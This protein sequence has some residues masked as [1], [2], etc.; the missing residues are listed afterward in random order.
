MTKI[1]SILLTSIITLSSLNV[2]AKNSHSLNLI[3]RQYDIQDIEYSQRKQALTTLNS[4][5]RQGKSTGEKSRESD[6]IMLDS[7]KIQLNLENG[8][9]D[10]W[11]CQYRLNSQH[12]YG[13]ADWIKLRGKN[14]YLIMEEG[15]FSFCS[16]RE[17]SWSIQGSK[18]L[19]DRDKSRIRV[20]DAKLRIGKI[21]VLYIPYLSIPF[22]TKQN[23]RSTFPTY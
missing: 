11:E 1:L 22:W 19:R 4:F 10:L 9:L 21:P 2:I 18:L 16:P 12:E 3:S 7:S 13:S 8:N 23:K 15:I 17:N 20:W 6:P 14:R 5:D